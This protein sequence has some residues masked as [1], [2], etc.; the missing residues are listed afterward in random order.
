MTFKFGNEESQIKSKTKNF[1]SAEEARAIKFKSLETFSEKNV[2]EIL[3]EIFNIIKTTS[4]S[5][6]SDVAF[7]FK[8]DIP[9]ETTQPEKEEIA[10]IMLRLQQ[11]GY[12]VSLS[13]LV[14]S[15]KWYVESK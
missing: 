6:A 5:G 14:L 15:I 8:N 12:I 11:Y 7:D 2:N 10:E 9:K 1:I 13:T 3:D 4:V